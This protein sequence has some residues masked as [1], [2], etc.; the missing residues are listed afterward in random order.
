MKPIN[1]LHTLLLIAFA[2]VVLIN[3]CFYKVPEKSK[4]LAESIQVDWFPDHSE[5]TTETLSFKP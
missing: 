2:V 5:I 4:E 3:G 1:R